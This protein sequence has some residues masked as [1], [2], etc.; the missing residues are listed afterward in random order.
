M[1]SET[2]Y[3]RSG[4]IHIAYQV[5]GE[6]ELDLVF[7]PGW[8]SNVELVWEE[9]SARRFLERL[10]SFSRLVLFD[11]RGTGLSDPVSD[12]QLPTMEQRMD[13]VRA[14][15]DAAHMQSA[16][17]FGVSEGVPMSALFAATYPERTTALVLYG[18]YA[19]RRYSGDYPWAPTPEERQVF[20]DAIERQWGGV[21]D[22]GELAPSVAGDERFKQWW[23]TYLRRSASPMRALALARMNT[24][25]DIR[26]ILPTIRVPT[27]ILHRSGDH[28]V[29]VRGARWMATQIPNVRYVELPGED[30]LPF[31]GDSSALLDEIQEFLTGQ[32][33]AVVPDSV[34]GT[35]LFTD[36]VESTPRAAEL[37][38][39]RWAAL[40]ENHF[41][42]LRQQLGRFRGKEVHTTG[43]GLLAT[44]DG[45]ARAVQC[46]RA[47]IEAVRPLGIQI[48]VGLHTG[49]Y[50]LIGQE[51]AGL[52]I[53]IAARVMSKAG[54][55]QVWVSSTVKDL[56]AGSGIEFA[57]EGMH[58]LKG[59]AGEWHLY[60]VAP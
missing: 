31:V 41:Q 38:N 56:I 25:I 37:G 34:L 20:F 18:G 57:D 3:A 23:A 58:A 39:T 2:R 51:V 7:V 21:V 36:M 1:S 30:H 49:E 46:G 26:S 6:G 5:V 15:M 17:L 47:M 60:S 24:E 54:A 48:R 55:S 33:A 45:P 8:V 14:V 22:L 9:A 12:D 35:L 43:D 52:A 16:A 4:D 27:L 44:F 10:A 19:K 29:D 42:V 11:K 28:D 32:R 50:E 13:D 53:H 40:V 59:V